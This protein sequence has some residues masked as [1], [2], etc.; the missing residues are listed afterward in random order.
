MLKT[1][2][3]KFPWYRN[4]SGCKWGPIG[5]QWKASLIFDCSVVPNDIKI[6]AK[7]MRIDMSGKV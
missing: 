2:A 7:K 4:N 5:M 1:Y 6:F 3:T